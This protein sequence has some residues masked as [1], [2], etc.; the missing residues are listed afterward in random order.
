MSKA[1]AKNIDARMVGSEPE[2]D[3]TKKYS[4]TEM[5][6]VYNWY[7][8]SHDISTTRHWIT[9]WMAA[10]GYEKEEIEKIKNPQN[11]HVS[12]TMATMCRIL[13]RGL[14][15]QDFR[16]SLVA[17]ISAGIGYTNSDFVDGNTDTERLCAP[18][19]SSNT[20]R[21]NPVIAY[22]DNILDQFYDSDYRPYDLGQFCAPTATQSQYNDA[23]QE[24]TALHVEISAISIGDDGY[25]HLTK[26]KHKR[27][28]K[29]L[30]DIIAHL[31]TKITVRKP[32]VP[33]KKTKQKKKVLK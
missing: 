23:I 8:Y 5:A 7:S 20:N 10:N 19:H 2:F 25:A 17:R 14:Q 27:Y 15:D 18:Q 33:R 22:I 3:S 24:Y 4:W 28:K 32:R 16:A 12:Q 30:E 11:P 26:A 1:V 31:K 29:L 13:S 21:N 6:Q 9:E